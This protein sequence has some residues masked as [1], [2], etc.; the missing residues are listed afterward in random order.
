MSHNKIS[1]DNPVK[2]PKVLEN[3]TFEEA[4]YLKRENI[5]KIRLFIFVY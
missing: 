4:T 3:Y 5:D 1:K 2:K